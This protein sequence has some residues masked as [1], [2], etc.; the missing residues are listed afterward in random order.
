VAWGPDDAVCIRRTR[1]AELLSTAELA[2]R[3]PHLAD[4][5]GPN[6]SEAVNAL[7]WNR[8]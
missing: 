8:S 5:I 1:I 2:E 3:Y 6:C 7:I 4:T